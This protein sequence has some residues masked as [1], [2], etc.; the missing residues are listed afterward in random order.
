MRVWSCDPVGVSAWSVTSRRVYHSGQ[1]LLSILERFIVIGTVS[2][3]A[4]L[5]LRFLSRREPNV[6]AAATI[7]G[8]SFLVLSYFDDRVRGWLKLHAENKTGAAVAELHRA[9]DSESDLEPLTKRFEQA[10][11]SFADCSGVEIL[12]FDRHQYSGTSVAIP[13]ATL[14]ESGFFSDGWVS[15]ASFGRT[16]ARS[17][18]TQLHEI[19]V[20]GKFAVL[21]C[22]Q[23]TMREPSLIVAFAERESELPFTD[24][25]IRLM[26]QLV[27]VADSLYIRARLALQAQQAE[28]LAAIGRL[29]LTILHELRNPMSTLKSFSQLLPEKIDD[30]VFLA[31][32]AEIIP[33][34][35]ER[36]ETLAQQLLD[37]SRPRKYNLQR[38]DRS[39]NCQKVSQPRAQ[40]QFARLAGPS[41]AALDVCDTCM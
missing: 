34:E 26:R 15:T 12:K 40:R 25:E 9:A 29:G 27:N 32:F 5:A 7:I 13:S 24:P 30:K 39:I 10:L 28:H 6:F 17:G 23:W 22:P 37:L 3:L 33:Q 31:E 14:H 20:Q 11:R 8:A 18:R 41:R 1:V 35:A 2:I 19:L 16:P 38:T 4:A 36:V 21:V